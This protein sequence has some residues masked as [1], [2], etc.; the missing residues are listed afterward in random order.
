M[1][2]ATR[3]ASVSIV[4]PTYNRAHLLP[5]ALE[6]IRAQTFHSWELI[7][8][9]NGS[10]DDTARVVAKMAADLRQT[11]HYVRLRENHSP[12]LAFN[13]GIDE[14]RASYVAFLCDDDSWLPHHLEDCVDALDANDDVDWI[15][16]AMCRVDLKTGRV[17][18]PHSFY[19]DDR[20]RPFLQLNARCRGRLRVIDDP[21]A[22]PCL[23]RHGG[24]G[25]LQASVLRRAVFCR[26]RLRDHRVGEDRFLLAEALYRGVR[27]AYFND[28][29]AKL[30][31][32]SEHNTAANATRPLDVRRTAWLRLLDAYD[33][34][35]R[36]IPLD[37]SGRLALRR[38]VA[39]ECFWTFAYGLLWMGGQRREAL[40]YLWRGIR[41]WPWDVRYW[42]TFL[43]CSLRAFVAGLMVRS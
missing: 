37:R 27:L 20:P 8:V 24:I 18:E 21:A 30:H 22:R 29:H 34:M 39:E 31:I 13:R 2:N 16:A 14:A 19:I 11:V 38:G 26:V 3:T 15:A 40:H 12:A 23:L 25:C 36:L 43:L 42:K 6:S 7:L 1:I 10:T 17:V 41:C 35:F 4:L 5:L 9:D 33:D 32:H 28:V